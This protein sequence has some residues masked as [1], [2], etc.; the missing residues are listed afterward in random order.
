MPHFQSLSIRALLLLSLG[1][2]GCSDPEKAVVSEQLGPQA[3][4]E[5]LVDDL[6]VVHI[7][8]ENDPD[9][10]FGAGYAMAQERLFQMELFRRRAHGTRAELLGADY[11]DDDIGARVFNFAK[12]GRADEALARENHP[13]DAKLIDA[14]TAGINL[15]ISEVASGK[16]PR[17]YGMRATEFDFVPEPWDSFEGYAIGKLLGFGM[18]N[19]LDQTILATAL[20][21]LAPDALQHLPILMPAH[22]VFPGVGSSPLQNP[23]PLQSGKPAP[24]PQ[25]D[26]GLM[27]QHY[28]P[29]MP[30]TASNNWAVAGKYTDNGKPFVCGDPHQSLTSPSRFFAFHMNSA[31]HGGS[32]DVTGFGFV[33]TPMVQLGHNAHVGWT[34]TTNFADVMD[35]WDVTPNDTAGTVDLG[36][37]TVSLEKRDEVFRVRAANGSMDEVTLEITDVP[38]YGVLLPEEMLPVPRALLADGQLLF[39]WTGFSPSSEAIAYLGLDRAKNVDDMEAALQKLDVGAINLVTADA[40]EIAYH[41][42]ARIPD[43]GDPSKREMPWRTIIDPENPDS[44]WTRGD[45][46]ADKLPRRRNPAEGYLYSANTDPWGF[47]QDGVVENDPFYYGSFYANGFRG[48]RIKDSLES[49]VTAGNPIDRAAMENMQRDVKS[50]L[51]D[52][53]VPALD[54]AVANIETDP[55]LAAYKGRADL[56]TLAT[57]LSTWNRQMQLDAAEPVVFNGLMWFA[58]RRAFEKAAT[59]TLF[60]AIQG[61]SPPFFLGQLSNLLTGRIAD[62]SYFAPDGLDVLLVGALDDTSTWL[63]DRFGAFDAMFRLRDVQGASFETEYEGAWTTTPVPVGG[64]ADTINVAPTAFFS[65]DGVLSTFES[66]EMALYRMVIGFGADDVPE[67]TL[68]FGRGNSADPESPFFANQNQAWTDVTYQKLAFRRPDVEARQMARSILLAKSP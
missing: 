67:A 68:N 50:Q 17:P 3:D 10:F 61:E 62:T 27:P 48:Q 44:Y 11:L 64:G 59:K 2:V 58:A 40:K 28:R 4:V 51:A 9:A 47:T 56:V 24:R 41:V 46:S 54:N 7:Y 16:A 15:R 35:L 52:V 12:L 57:R 25:V 43:R 5:L 49:L 14:W 33:G 34:A 29:I 19:N 39:N 20:S 30:A 6:G 13:E 55:A 8:A 42:H 21:R 38:G 32:L 23:N 63:T 18:S 60:G 66:T 36:G 45:L 65:G 31:D 26:P 37:K 22:D 53:L 1:L